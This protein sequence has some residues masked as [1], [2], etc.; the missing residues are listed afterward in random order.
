MPVPSRLAASAAVLVALAGALST[1]AFAQTLNAAQQVALNSVDPVLANAVTTARNALTAAS[2]AT[3]PNPTELAAHAAAVAD[4]DLALAFARAGL[5]ARL[6]ASPNRLNAAQLAAVARG[7]RGA[8][9]AGQATGISFAD[10]PKV[11]LWPNG[12]P[13]ALGDT[14]ADKPVLAVYL[15]NRPAGSPPAPAVVIAPGGGYLRVSTAGGEGDGAAQWFNSL[16]ISAFVLRYRVT[17]YHYPA[18]TDDGQR[19]I[20]L[21]RARA[22]EFGIDPNR[23]GMLGFSAGGHLTAATA[24]IFDT[25]KPDAADPVD[26]VSSRPDF[27][28]LMYAVISFNPEVAGPNNLTA[29][30][31]SGRNLLGDNPDPELV[32]Q[33]SLETRVT[34]DTP[35]TFLYNGTADTLVASENSFRFYNALRK[36]GVP[37]EVHTFENGVHATG[38]SLNDPLK[39]L[40]PE[41]LKTWLRVR[42]VVSFEIP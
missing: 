10:A 19:A 16:G 28:M 11:L 40:L 24:T 2:L 32:K 5:V 36:A 17:P 33:M 7:G 20:R 31:S 12:T 14:D 22:A 15:V 26:R 6:Q 3:A 38:L 39:G 25:G 18:E 29:Y 41:L 1:P 35:P 13:G 8:V 23:I 4:A 21:V 42:G 30:A 9:P 34:K 37:T 27:A